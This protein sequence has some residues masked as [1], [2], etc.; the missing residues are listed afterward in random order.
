MSNQ[1]HNSP[2]KIKL[3]RLF[4]NFFRTINQIPANWGPNSRFVLEANIK[5]LLLKLNIELKVTSKSTIFE[6]LGDLVFNPGIM[7]EY[8]VILE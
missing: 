8:Q 5:A 1:V 4:D 6:L 3:T 7:A 2:F